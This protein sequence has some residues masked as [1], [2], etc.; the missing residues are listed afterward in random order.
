VCAGHWEM[1]RRVLRADPG[2]SDQAL[3]CLDLAQ[4]RHDGGHVERRGVEPCQ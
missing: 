4:A 3:A 2:C 1:S